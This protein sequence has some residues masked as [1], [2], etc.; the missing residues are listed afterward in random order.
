[1]GLGPCMG[2]EAEGHLKVVEQISS[3]CLCYGYLQL[4]LF[5]QRYMKHFG[6]ETERY[7]PNFCPTYSCPKYVKTQQ[8]FAGVSSEVSLLSLLQ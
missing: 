5:C 8:V 2:Y 1:M 3:A 7:V 4:L 6:K